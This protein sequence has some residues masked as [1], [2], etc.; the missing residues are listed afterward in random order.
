M[1]TEEV[2]SFVDDSE[3][4]A[5]L[6]EKSLVKEK[7]KSPAEISAEISKRNQRYADKIKDHARESGKYVI[8]GMLIG[9]AVVGATIGLGPALVGT[10]GGLLL[11]AGFYAE[12]AYLASEFMEG[13]FDEQE[14]NPAKSNLNGEKHE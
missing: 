9:A 7:E 2:A 1:L 12:G 5:A 4:E 14:T 11:A 6:Q 8:L 3:K 13:H 10:A